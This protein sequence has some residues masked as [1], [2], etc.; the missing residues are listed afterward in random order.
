MRRV[1]MGVLFFFMFFLMSSS[2]WANVEQIKAYKAAHE[3][4]KPK[5]I[6]CHALEKPKKEDGLHELNE[7]GK[8]AKDL[9]ET[10]DCKL[11]D[12]EIYGSIGKNQ[13]E[14]E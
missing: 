11:T 7:Y 4:A 8:K 6:W 13:K 3:G 5:C 1:K 10:P 12:A 14:D 2:A 9:K